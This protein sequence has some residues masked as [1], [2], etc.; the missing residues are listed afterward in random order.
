MKSV[1]KIRLKSDE[2]FH[3]NPES[4]RDFFFAKSGGRLLKINF[5]DILFVE[6]LRDYVNIRTTKE[7]IIVLENLKSLEEKLPKN[8]LRIH[9][10]FIANLKK[11]S[12]IEGN[13]LSIE[14]FQ[15]SIG[16]NYKPALNGWLGK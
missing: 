16:E 13:R 9:K 15:I 3:N 10:S 2:N 8:F 1:E 4:D 11:I 7:E 5:D 14:N 6:G 12:A